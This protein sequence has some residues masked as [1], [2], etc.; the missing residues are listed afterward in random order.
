MNLCLYEGSAKKNPNPGGGNAAFQKEVDPLIL[1]TAYKK[2]RFYIFSRR[3]PE[4]LQHDNPLGHGGAHKLK[5]NKMADVGRDALNERPSK[6]DIQAIPI[7]QVSSNIPSE[8]LWFFEII[9]RLC[10]ILHL[11]KSM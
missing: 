9:L 5:K 7:P 10:Y 2:N 6:D 4:D 11:G 1:C 8:V 3:Q